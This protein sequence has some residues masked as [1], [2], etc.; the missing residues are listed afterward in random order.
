MRLSQLVYFKTVAETGTIAGAAKRLFVSAPAVSIAVSNL[1]KEL[2]VPLFV[3]SNNRLRLNDYGE[4][5]LNRVEQILTDLNR[6]NMEVH[7]MHTKVCG[8]GYSY[9]LR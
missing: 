2:G 8:G 3:R 5:Y 9:S 1:E 7:S 4:F 6:A